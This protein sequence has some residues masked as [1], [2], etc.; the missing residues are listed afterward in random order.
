[1][2]WLIYKSERLCDDEHVYDIVKHCVGKNFR[3][4]IT[5]ALIFT[6]HHFVQYLEGPGEAIDALMEDIKVDIRHKNVQVMQ[7]GERNDRM[8]DK[9]PLTSR[10]VNLDMQKAIHEDTRVE[11]LL[12]PFIL[13]DGNFSPDD[14]RKM[15]DL[16]S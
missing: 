2:N 16:N 7:S 11:S 15:V 14:I 8:L 13:K 6:D 5:S 10:F 9:Y 1:M 12:R 3:R 4:G